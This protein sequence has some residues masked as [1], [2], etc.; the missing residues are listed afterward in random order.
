M[1]AIETQRSLVTI[2]TRAGR[3]IVDVPSNGVFRVVVGPD[4]SVVAVVVIASSQTRERRTGL[5]VAG[6][7]VARAARPA[8]RWIVPMALRYAAPAARWLWDLRDLML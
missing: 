3:T 6:A 7:R 1:R 4:A 2:I 8:L 5:R